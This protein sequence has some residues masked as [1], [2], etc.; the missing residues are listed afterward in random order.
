M[1]WF[2]RALTALVFISALPLHATDPAAPAPAPYFDPATV[3]AAALL[4]TPPKNDSNDTEKELEIMLQA[5]ADR[6]PEQ[7]ARIKA[8]EH[9]N[10][11]AFANVLGPWFASSSPQ[12]APATSG[13]LDRVSASVKPVVEAAKGDWDRPRPFLV[14]SRIIPA[15]GRP[16]DG[17]YPS[18][19]SVQ[20]TLDALVLAELEPDAK[21][22]IL[23]RGREIGDDQVIAGVHFPS[24]VLAGRVLGQSIFKKLMADP[25]FRQDLDAARVE[26]ANAMKKG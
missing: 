8:E 21:D 5:Q 22:A 26:V 16:A 2:L 13:L 14:N 20:A 18:G 10:V 15:I 12:T 25:Q 4:P 19:N 3:N 11:G 24:D 7:V 23:A 9:Y 6:T 17:S 1:K